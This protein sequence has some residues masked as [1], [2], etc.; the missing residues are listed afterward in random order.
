MVV[1][2]QHHRRQD[3]SLPDHWCFAIACEYRIFGFEAALRLFARHQPCVIEAMWRKSWIFINLTNLGSQAY[4]AAVRELA[5]AQ[6]HPNVIRINDP[7]KQAMRLAVTVAMTAAMHAAA[8]PAFANDPAQSWMRFP[9]QRSDSTSAPDYDRSFIKEWEANPPKGYPTLSATNVEPMKAA[10]KRYSDIAERGGWEALP[11]IV[12]QP[13]MNHSAV[14]ILKQ[15]LLASGDL[16]EQSGFG[17]S[18]DYY[19][20]KAVKRFQAS[21]GLTP[22]GIVDKRTIAAL[23]V[24][25]AARLRQLRA[26]LARLQEFG[27]SLP[28]KYVVVNIPS[29][30]IEAVEGDR[31]VSRHSGVVGKI[32]RP[33]PLLRS[34]IYELNFNPVWH[35]PPT[36]I[37]KDL[38]PKGQDMQRKNQ[39]VL[40]KYG[41]DAYDAS[42]KKLDSAKINW[43]S[44]AAK[45][46]TFKQQP[47][48]ENPLGFLKINFH[49]NY[50]VYM[51]DTPSE[52]MFG[53]NFRAA[54]S[55]CVRV[56]GIEH[57]AQWLLID[58]GGWPAERIDQMKKSG[59]RQ[60]VALKKPMP[61]YFVYITAWATEDGIV[62]FRRDLYQKDGVGAVAGAY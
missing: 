14:G 37:D 40:V 19:V 48:R 31:V 44:S 54:S 18:Y 42:G 1:A 13:G 61:L 55:G 32:D 62:N 17:D 46:L 3:H 24:P 52:T 50:S 21:N 5:T 29:A 47:G 35:L 57:L 25:A 60:N 41:I 43:S 2:L 12:L 11:E 53:R 22:T 16:K 8:A 59:E 58:N 34:A 56:Q 7:L 45:G 49:N 36:V 10:I 9:G 6:E 39:D 28:K 51:H 38:V 20:E 15:R 33:T 30:Q 26:N 27:R 4:G 23:N